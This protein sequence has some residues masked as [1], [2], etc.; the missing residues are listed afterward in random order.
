MAIPSVDIQRWK[1]NS[2]SWGAIALGTEKGD[3]LYI[4]GERFRISSGC[5][6]KKSLV[7]WSVYL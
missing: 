1:Q 7:L 3:G 4:K 6:K 2:E 5:L